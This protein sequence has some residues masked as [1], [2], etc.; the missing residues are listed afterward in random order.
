VFTAVAN[1]VLLIGVAAFIVTEAFRRLGAAPAVPGVP[2][3]VVALVGVVV[4]IVVALLLRP[5]SGQSTGTRS[6]FGTRCQ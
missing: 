1:A 2:L 3:I 6:G 4:N 5:H